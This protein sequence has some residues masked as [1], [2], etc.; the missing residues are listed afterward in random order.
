MARGGYRPGAGRPKK[1]ATKKAVRKE[2]RSLGMTPLEYML[3]VMNNPAEDPTRRDRMAIAAA[4]FVHS[5]AE[6][7]RGKRESAEIEANE[8]L[9]GNNDQWGDDLNPHAVN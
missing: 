2:A 6:G 1:S 4:P 3:N 8:V 7:I 5:K 9:K